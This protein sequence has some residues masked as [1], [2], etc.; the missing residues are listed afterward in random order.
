M[1]SF[2]DDSVEVVAVQ[3]PAQ[4]GWTL[5]FTAAAAYFVRCDPSRILVA[6]PTEHEAQIWSKDRFTPVASATEALKEL[7]KPAK[8]RDG[9]NSVLHKRFPGGAIKGVGA[10][11]PTGLA[12]WPAK[13]IMLDEVDRYPMSA[14]DEGDPISLVKKRA[15]TYLRR[16]GKLVAGST[17]DI[18]GLSLIEALVE[19]GDKRRFL[20]P[21]HHQQCRHEQILEFENLEWGRDEAG[22]ALPETASY[23]CQGCGVPWTDLERIS[24]IRNGRW[25]ASAPRTNVRSYIIDGLLSPDVTHAELAREWYASNT[26]ERRKVFV[27]TYLGRTWSEESDAPD[28]K[29]LFRKKESWDS[30]ILP[31][32]VL[33]L[34]CG[35]D[36]Q[37]NRLEYRVWGW[38]R[39]G[40][41]WLIEHDIIPFGPDDPNAWNAVDQLL[42]EDK[43]WVSASGELMKLDRLCVDSSAFT[44]EVYSWGRQYKFD[45]RVM[46]VKGDARQSVVVGSRQVQEFTKTG[47]KAKYGVAVT[48]IGT[49]KAKDYLI[50][51]MRLDPPIANE[52][53]PPGYIHL[54]DWVTEDEVQQMVSERK[55]K[56]VNKKGYV[57]IE[58]RKKPGDRN[59]ALD[60][61]VYAHAGA[62][63]MGL[64]NAPAFFWE[65]REELYKRRKPRPEPEQRRVSDIVSRDQ[66]RAQ[67]L[68]DLIRAGVQSS[69]DPWLD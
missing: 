10:N 35:L 20:V 58:W 28:W 42:S 38:G 50:R 16:G 27:N 45:E 60:C 14:G 3:K 51:K 19:Q 33:L 4:V 47:V 56:K 46:L 7:I 43:S 53:Y 26:D 48:I 23:I 39:D 61:F 57:D 17:P 68:S 15:Q 29:S 52:G 6:M 1:D 65:D 62:V 11:S 41:C 37:K 25:E 9:T 21:C 24:N 54:N 30:N 44:E 63:A 36:V 32:G 12:S 55:I 22:N 31:N 59:E 13:R 40:E 69:G 34:T 49:N 18:T 66:T 8:S 5:A 67:R 64:W 2:V